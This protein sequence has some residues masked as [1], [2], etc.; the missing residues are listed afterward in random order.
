MLEFCRILLPLVAVLCFVW[1]AWNCAVRVLF[2]FKAGV[3][4]VAAGQTPLWKPALLCLGAGLV[5]QLLFVIWACRSGTYD[6]VLEA[7]SA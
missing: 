6:S 5:V 3:A 4:P 7:L 2:P 1:G